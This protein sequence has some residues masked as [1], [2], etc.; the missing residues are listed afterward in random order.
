MHT[1]TVAASRAATILFVDDD[2]QVATVARRTLEAL[3][4][5]VAVASDGEE[6]LRVLDSLPSAPD[7][8]VS[9]L[10]MPSLGGGEM[11]RRALARWPWLRVLFIS[12]YAPEEGNAADVLEHHDAF[13]S[14]PFTPRILAQRVTEVLNGGR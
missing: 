4:H 5:R 8:L 14:K 13:L 1:P 2:P 12:A 6:G 10:L 3:G 7:L 9:D 11:A